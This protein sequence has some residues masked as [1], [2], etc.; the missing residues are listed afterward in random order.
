MKHVVITAPEQQ[1][2]RDKDNQDN[3]TIK[4][5]M[6]EHNMNFHFS[7]PKQQCSLLTFSMLWATYMNKQNLMKYT[8]F[9]TIT[10]LSIIMSVGLVSIFF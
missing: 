10:E 3:R 1:D 8:L 4:S 6:A 7:K 9:I 5:L 2:N